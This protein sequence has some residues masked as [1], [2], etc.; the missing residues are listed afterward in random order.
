MKRVLTA[1]VFAPLIVYVVLFGPQLVFLAVVLAVA[2]LCFREYAALVERYGIDRPG[3]AGVAAGVL[4]LLAPGDVGLLL[5]LVTLAALGVAI[6]ASSVSQSLPRAAAL[7]LGVAYTFGTLRW[8]VPLRALN[9]HWLLFA[10]LLVWV[11]DAVAYYTGR[12][13]G[14]HKLAPVISPGKTWEGGIGSLVGS[15]LLAVLYVPRFAPEVELPVA[16]G[17]AAAANLAGQ[18]GD[19]AESAL[20]RGAGVKDSGHMLPGHGGWL[21]RVDSSLFAIPVV[22][23]LAAWITAHA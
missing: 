2:L 12:A 14:R 20:K 11:G 1:L 16:I 17:L 21:D 19:L 22:Y 5:A 3:P 18:V 7:L 8:A 23:W 10:L 15:V 13:L 4:V 6:G 9:P